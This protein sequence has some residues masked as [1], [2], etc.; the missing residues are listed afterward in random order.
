MERNLF[1]FEFKELASL[2]PTQQ[3]FLPKLPPQSERQMLCLSALRKDSIYFLPSSFQL[4]FMWLMRLLF[5][6]RPHLPH[7]PIG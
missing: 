7:H 6:L 5:G 4:S 3:A 2:S 1:P